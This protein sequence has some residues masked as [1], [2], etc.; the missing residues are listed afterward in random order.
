[1]ARVRGVASAVGLAAALSIFVSACGTRQAGC[2]PRAAAPVPQEW[3]VDGTITSVA[4]HCSTIFVGG[5]FGWIGRST[6]AAALVD[7]SSGR[8]LPFP[9]FNGEVEAV[10][11]D[12]RGGWFVGGSFADVDGRP[13]HALAHVRRG[14]VDWCAARVAEVRQLAPGS[15][16]L[17]VS[18]GPTGAF[19]CCARLMA[20]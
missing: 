10:V 14:S 20:F 16:R 6:G 1:M 2:A 3:T 13:C 17:Y 19:S 4:T 15:D 9:R 11:S 12:R 8:R 18:A 5:S 7:R